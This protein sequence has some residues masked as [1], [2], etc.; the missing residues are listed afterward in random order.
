MARKKLGTVRI[1]DKDVPVYSEKLEGLWGCFIEI[2]L[3][4]RMNENIPK[5][6]FKQV[7]THECMHAILCLSGLNNILPHETEE[8]ICQV[9]EYHA[10]TAIK[11]AQRVKFHGSKDK[12]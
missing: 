9:M 7:L 6:K 1:M 12:G 2:P 11:S 8:S 5:S 10:E 3:E 4:I